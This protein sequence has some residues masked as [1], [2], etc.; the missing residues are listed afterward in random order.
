VTIHVVVNA[1]THPVLARALRMTGSPA[2]RATCPGCGADNR[3][4]TPFV[5]HD[6]GVPLFAL[7]LPTWARHEEL[8]RRAALLMELAQA[9]EAV[10]PAY[11]RHFTVL[12]GGDA[13][14][15]HLAAVA[16]PGPEEDAPGHGGTAGAYP[17]SNEDVLAEELDEGAPGSGGTRPGV[18]V[19]REAAAEF[20]EPTD[21]IGMGPGAAGG[22]EGGAGPGAVDGPVRSFVEVVTRVRGA[23]P[24]ERAEATA[25]AEFD[26]ERTAVTAT[27]SFA[28]ESAAAGQ[29]VPEAAGSEQDEDAEALVVD[30]PLPGDRP[31]VDDRGEDSERGTVVGGSHG[32]LIERWIASRQTSLMTV[33]E[34][35][36]ARLAAALD[37]AAL[38]DLLAE[39]LQVRL[40]LHPAAGYPVVT[41]ALGTPAVVEGNRAGRSPQ[42][43]YFD[44]ALARDRRFLEALRHEF[45]LTLDLYDREYLPV[46]RRQVSAP[47]AANVGYVLA[48]A[49]ELIEAAPPPASFAAAVRT[50]HAPGGDPHGWQHP[51]R[52]V[53][54]AS[55][56][57]A[58]GTPR[59]VQRALAM[60]R[61]FSS[62]EGEQYLVLTRGYPLEV[63]RRKR[64]RVLHRAVELGLW[65]GGALAQV[66]VSEG[67]ARSRKQLIQ[68]LCR[69]FAALP[70][71]ARQEMDAQALAESWEALQREAEA[72]GLEPAGDAGSTGARAVRAIDS[73]ESPVVSG[74]IGKPGRDEPEPAGA[75]G[76]SSA[77]QSTQGGLDLIGLLAQPAH[78]F[79]AALELAHR[80]EPAAA[81]PVFAA[82]GE[83]KREEAI[84]VLAAAVSFGEAAVAPAVAGLDSERPH[85]RQGCALLL[86][87]ASSERASEALGEALVDE[88]TA[89]WREIARA[90]GWTG[91]RSLRFLLSRAREA[92]QESRERIAWALAHVVVRQGD[93]MLR[94]TAVAGGPGGQVARRAI[95][96]AARARVD[97]PRAGSDTASAGSVTAS[98]TRAF[99]DHL[100]RGVAA[101]LAPPAGAEPPGVSGETR[102]RASR[103]LDRD[104]GEPVPS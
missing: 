92:S 58:L 87:L 72:L 56:L 12:F 21:Q 43:F 81:A 24:D 96:L 13:L 76:R 18:P 60:T 102:P 100:P 80:G 62:P 59:Q 57:A 89:L 28:E 47:L 17:V 88:P 11:V 35:G 44:V 63:W 3:V 98:L 99:L 48:A 53:F 7:V 65:M 71:A 103:G 50:L 75:A 34:H 86:G 41:M 37:G 16:G 26:D 9:S 23:D 83:M 33:D 69:H 54:R 90:L 25:P 73:A 1:Q 30:E 49:E 77:E 27:F 31:R 32:V 2:N 74:V 38:E 20:E 55:S 40:Q 5:Y 45:A 95:E 82:L 6:P 68:T 19:Q 4:D 46:R 78:R 39:R 8:A 14:R 94:R 15:A 64:L 97:D 67:I 42:L 101:R 104:E 10:V 91:G 29:Q 85:L 93:A 22:G 84:R 66:A 61:R 36:N 70:S 52:A 51:E 79:S